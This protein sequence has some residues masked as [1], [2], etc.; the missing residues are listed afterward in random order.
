[1]NWLGTT[2][3]LSGQKPIGMGMRSTQKSEK[4]VTSS[5]DQQIPGRR[6]KKIFT[7]P[8]ILKENS[9]P[10]Q[11]RRK[12][13]SD[14]IRI[15]NKPAARKYGC[16]VQT[17]KH[18][19]RR[20]DQ[21]PQEGFK[22]RSRRP[23]TSPRRTA[24]ELEARI[25]KYRDDKGMSGMNLKMQYEVTEVCAATINRICKRHGRVAPRKRKH[26][27][28]KDLR[29]VKEALPSLT[30]FELDGKQ[31]N[32]IPEFYPDWFKLG[33]PLWQI[34]L[35]D[36]KTTAQFIAYGTGETT[37]VVS[38]FLTYV[39][40]YFRRMGLDTSK[41]TISTDHGS[42]AGGKRKSF[43]EG[44]LE[45]FLDTY[46]G[47]KHR[48]IYH[49]N[50]HGL[51]ERAH[52]LIEQYFYKRESFKSTGDFFMGAM[53]YQTWFNL[54]RKNG[55]RWFRTPLEIL[56]ETRPDLDPNILVLPPIDLDAHADIYFYKTDPNYKPMTK[57]QF[58][59][60]VTPEGYERLFSRDLPNDLEY[61]IGNAKKS[62]YTLG[63]EDVMR[64][65]EYFIDQ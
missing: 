35:R 53:N 41:M 46:Y 34:T 48:F 14:A 29:M 20:L 5:C 7:Y 30:H 16:D 21:D 12:M 65:D 38:T 26:Q 4:K 31:I 42:F 59:Q 45:Y 10:W 13:A 9:D 64:F 57:R 56:K 23:K 11:A 39:L 8:E 61:F 49:K 50:S 2:K 15:G 18:W 3:R 37:L 43:N 58:F 27:I 1:M 24:S 19:R 33:L 47:I 52:G 28:K 60:D 62:S 17:I 36:K 32:D 54:I 22:N 6:R 55:H 25:L 63:G 40:E 44:Q 51:V